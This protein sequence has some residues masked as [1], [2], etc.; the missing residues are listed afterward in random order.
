MSYR[1]VTDSSANINHI[2]SQLAFATVPL[3]II[4]AEREFVDHAA[5]N[6]AEMISYLQEYK[7]KSSTACPS[8]ADWLAVFGEA[9]AVFCFTITSKLSGSYNAARLAKEDYEAAHP[10]R[11]VF[12]V[13]SLSTGGE[14]QLLIERTAQLLTRG[15]TPT[16]VYREVCAYQ[17]KT[18][19]LFALQSLNNLANNGRVN[20][21]LAKI[22]GALGMRVLGRASEQGEL[23]TL[24]KCRGEKKALEKLVSHMSEMGYQ[25]GAVRLDHCCNLPAAEQLCALIRAQYP[26]AEITIG[27]TGGL[28]SFYAEKGGLILGFETE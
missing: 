6:V 14:M 21:L 10:N 25:G 17:K 26:N 12:L 28:C 16:E 27:E 9:E 24:S 20:P 11:T 3:K 22:S 5:L 7:G 19:L 18:R 1:I 4:T 2:D 15:K 8:V 13:D 23:E